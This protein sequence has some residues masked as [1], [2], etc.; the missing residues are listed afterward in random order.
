MNYIFIDTAEG[1]RVLLR[2]GDKY[3]YAEDLTNAGAETLMPT[4]DRLL[5]ES[6]VKLD[7]KSVV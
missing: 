3:R 5:S 7:R 1:T 6:G 4:V 2:A